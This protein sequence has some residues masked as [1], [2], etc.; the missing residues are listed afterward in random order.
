MADPEPE[1]TGPTLRVRRQ[2]AQQWPAQ[3][4]LATAWEQSIEIRQLFRDNKAHLTKWP[5]AELVGATS[6]RALALNVPVVQ[7]ALA[8]WC[9][10]SETPKT[11]AID[12][13][14]QEASFCNPLSSSRSAYYDA[15]LQNLKA[16]N[17][18]NP[19]MPRA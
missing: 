12:W 2:A 16:L 18:L 15:T 11:M 17:I 13:L 9:G 3:G 7:I 19:Y 8:V 14:K 10:N 6:L 5:S 1:V 4:A